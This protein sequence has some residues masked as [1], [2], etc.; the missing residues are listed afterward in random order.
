MRTTRI[1]TVPLATLLTAAAVAGPAAAVPADVGP[2]TADAAARRSARL[3][4]QR[5]VLG[6]RLGLGGHRRHWRSRSTRDRVRRHDGHAP[7]TTHAAPD[8]PHPLASVLADHA[9]AR[10]Q[11]GDNRRWAPVEVMEAARAEGTFFAATP[12]GSAAS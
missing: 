11:C 9:L 2:H 12:G 6:L 8:R 10:F 5:A 1:V 3:T 4:R 7:P